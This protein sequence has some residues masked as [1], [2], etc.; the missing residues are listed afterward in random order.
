MSE[1]TL[2]ITT[3]MTVDEI[4]TIVIATVSKVNEEH[5]LYGEYKE[6]ELDRVKQAVQYIK[7]S[8]IY[9]VHIPD[10]SID[11]IKNIIKKY[12]REY[13]VEYI[14]FDYIWNSMRL[15]SE[16]SSKTRMGGL[17]EHQLLLVFSTELKPLHNN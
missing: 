12:N 1:P 6:G 8:P 4:Q 5:I 3:E 2:Y 15:M 14:Y 17:K 9:I 16:V 11:D 7:S 10:F 13:R